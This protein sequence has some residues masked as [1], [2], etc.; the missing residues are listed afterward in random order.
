MGT[1]VAR[2]GLLIGGAFR[3]D[4]NP[5]DHAEFT[6]LPTLHQ[7]GLRAKGPALPPALLVLK[8]KPGHGQRHQCWRVMGKEG[9]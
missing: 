4:L 3:G 1:L 2:D 9:R 5:G 7:I 8:A 6:L